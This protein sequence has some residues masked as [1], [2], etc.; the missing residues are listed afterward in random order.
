MGAG[1]IGKEGKSRFGRG[2]FCYVRWAGDLF[3]RIIGKFPA[4]HTGL[5]RAGLLETH[6]CHHLYPMKVANGAAKGDEVVCVV[7]KHLGPSVVGL[8]VGGTRD[9]FQGP[10]IV[11]FLVLVQ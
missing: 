4:F 2:A 11:F 8:A 7:I 1:K 9:T 3:I 10:A 6:P 5:I